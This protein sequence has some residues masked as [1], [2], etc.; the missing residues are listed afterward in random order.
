MEV[1]RIV[2]LITALVCVTNVLGHPPHRNATYRAAVYEQKPFSA[3]NAKTRDE[4]LIGM[5]RNIA[6]MERQARKA[7]VQASAFVF[8]I[9]GNLLALHKSIL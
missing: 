3:R 9:L 4:A 2:S 6:K 5:N 8:L 1:C 7:S